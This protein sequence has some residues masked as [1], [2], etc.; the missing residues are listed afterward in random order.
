MPWLNVP[1][2]RQTKPGWCLPACVAMAAAYWQQPLLQDDVA[3]WLGTDDLIGT[4]ASRVQRMVRHGFE[5][6]YSTGSLVNLEEWLARQVPLILFIMSGELSYWK[7]NTQ[8]AVVLA[9][10][11]EGDTHLFDPGVDT[12]PITV[13][14]D[15][16]MLAW[17]P[18]DYTYASLEPSP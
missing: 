1:H 3:R 10:F 9:G 4:P 17:S 14:T 6:T 7:V 13:S 15:D 12:A 5:V 16:L 8:H 11:T 18:F 2:L